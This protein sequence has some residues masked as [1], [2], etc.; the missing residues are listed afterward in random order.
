MK[1]MIN[2]YMNNLS[3]YILICFLTFNLFGDDLSKEQIEKIKEATQDYF[4]APNFTLK[5][6]NDSLYVLSDMKGKVVL[7]NFWATWCAPCRTEMPSLDTLQNQIGGPQ[8]KIITIASGRNNVDQMKQFFSESEIK[9]L[10]LYRDPK[11]KVASS[12]G[13]LGLPATILV[14]PMNIELARLIGSIDWASTD[15]VNFFE[16]LKRLV[17]ERNITN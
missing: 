14:G 15:S 11:G 8:F 9:N 5:S 17:Q 4:K 6:T 12:L 10:T 13:I 16:G 1:V 3:K 2:L 7:L